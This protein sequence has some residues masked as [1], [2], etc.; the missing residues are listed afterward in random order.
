[1]IQAKEGAAKFAVTLE[2]AAF[3]TKLLQVVLNKGRASIKVHELAKELF[4]NIE[5]FGL[6]CEELAKRG[7]LDLIDG[8]EKSLANNE[9]QFA[10]LLMIDNV[11]ITL[12]V[13]QKGLPMDTGPSLDE[14]E[15]SPLD[16]LKEELIE[17]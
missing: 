2:E 8:E 5:D 1:M 17:A 15:E 4:M 10:S 6:M 9:V 12:K 14:P 16:A 13:Q 11:C 7:V 3:I